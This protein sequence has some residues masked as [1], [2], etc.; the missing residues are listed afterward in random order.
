MPGEVLA[1]VHVE[2]LEHDGAFEVP[3]HRRPDLAHSFSS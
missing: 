2:L 1:P 3:H